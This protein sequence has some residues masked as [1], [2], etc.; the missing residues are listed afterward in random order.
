MFKTNESHE[1]GQ[2]FTP[3][4]QMSPRLKKKLKGNWSDIFYNEL[5]CKIDELIFKPL[6]SDHFG[7]GNF[8][9][10]ILIGLEIIKELFSLTD[11]QLLERYHFDL[12]IRRSLGLKDLNEHIL[13]DRTLYYF[14]SS[15]AEYELTHGENLVMQVFKD[16]RDKIIEE[17]GIKTGLQRTDSTLIGANIK[18]MNRLMLF[19][20][21]LSNFVNDLL[22]FKI[23][24]SEVIEKLVK[25]DEDAFTY[26]LK[27][28]KYLSKTKE[29]GEYIYSLITVHGLNPDIKELKSFKDAERLLKDQCNIEE[30][31]LDLKE[32]G[33]I[34]SSSMQNPADVDATYRKK[35]NEEHRGYAAHATETCDKENEIQVVTDVDVVPN[36]VDDAKVLSEKIEGFK[37]ET[38]LDTIILDGAFVSDDMRDVCKEN[39]IKIVASAI[40]GKQ[41]SKE[42]DEMLTSLDFEID[43]A[44]G[45]VK[46]CP[47]GVSPRSQKV[48]EGKVTANFDV[49]ICSV[50]EKKDICPVYSS[51]KQ[52]RIIIDGTRTW[53]DER[54]ELLKTDEY[55]EL[56]NLRPPVE[57]LMEKLKPKYL[58]GRTLFRGLGRVKNR[59]ILRAIGI[60]FRRYNS[61]KLE[62]LS[63]ILV[64]LKIIRRIW[65]FRLKLANL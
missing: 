28:D 1:Q 32:A 24:I 51:P 44:T 57:G 31:K 8:P 39:D 61:Y 21:V 2:M 25:D 46:S 34:S 12:L 47:A 22:S 45:E 11:E 27:K 42:S 16:G 18:K 35:R 43:D 40:R 60:N 56:C 15:V 63:K 52:S 17:L 59:M 5:F 58:S 38:G 26:R 65:I 53:L 48:E 23:S 62:L 9:V 29:I 49:S 6:Y 14:R 19:H 41:S 37:E 64:N 30:S 20:K 4:D 3:E 13:A 7:R 36:N 10:N 33:D 55:R 50:C 54:N